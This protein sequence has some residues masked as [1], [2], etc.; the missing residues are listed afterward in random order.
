[1]RPLHPKP[2]SWL[3]RRPGLVLLTLAALGGAGFGGARLARHVGAEAHYRAARRHLEQADRAQRRVH[4]ACAR[5]ELARCLDIWPHSAEV[6]FLAARTARRQGDYADAARQL[7]LAGKL[8]WV[9]EALGVERA[10][11]AAQR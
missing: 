11:L 6:H 3:G 8:G 7:G 5:E 10:L 2:V 1:M 9:E 4:L